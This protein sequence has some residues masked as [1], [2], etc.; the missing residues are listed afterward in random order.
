MLV[1]IAP[2]E[3]EAHGLLALMEL[4][5]SR[6]AAR[7]DAA[8]E[9][10]LL[11]DQNR[12]R[13]DRLQIRR[14]MQALRRARELGGAGGFYVLQAAIVACHAEAGSADETDWPRIAQLYAELAALV[15]SPIIELNRAVAVGM[16]EG[17]AGGAGDRRSP[18]RTSPRSKPIICS[19]ACAATCCTS[20]AATTRPAPRSK[21]PR[22]LPATAA[23][24]SC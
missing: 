24:A 21:P 9:P 22:H 8:G 5:A 10:I 7:T 17:P 11:L 12:A 20:S 18:R 3:P 4:N 1:S 19:A 16:A 23:N 2:H 14:G 13:W 6:T 15:P